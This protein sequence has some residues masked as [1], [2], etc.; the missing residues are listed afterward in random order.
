MFKCLVWYLEIDKCILGIIISVV[1]VV[2]IVDDD[3]NGIIIINF[4]INY[5]NG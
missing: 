4:L 1:I 2:V 3:D 5:Y